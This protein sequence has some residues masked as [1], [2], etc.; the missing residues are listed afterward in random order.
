MGIKSA[1]P[2]VGN[3]TNKQRSI[4]LLIVSLAF[5]MDLLD[6]TIINIALPSI[7][8]SLGASFATIQWMVAGYI[9]TFALLLITGGRMGDVFGYKKMFLTGVGG[10]TIAS[11]LCGIAG[12]PEVLV[13]ARLLQGAMA[14]LMVPQVMSMV[15]VMY[16]PGERSKVMGLFGM[17]GGMA[18]TLGP[19]VGGILINANIF[20]LDWRPIFLI[21]LPVGIF[22]FIAGMKF[23]PEGKSPHPLRLDMVGTGILVVALSMLIFPLIQ[24]REL[25]W[26]DWTFWMLAASVPAFA[27]FAWHQRYKDRKD[28]SA[29]VEPSLFKKRTFSNGLMLNLIVQ[30]GMLGFFLT[31]TIALQAGLGFSVLNAALVG[32][33]SAMGI[34][35]SIAVVTQKI[36]PLLGRYT[37]TLGTVV[38]A[39][40][41]MITAW[42]ISHY[43]NSVAGWQFAPGL[44]IT[45][46]GLGAIMGTMFSV[47]L[48]DVDPKHAGSASGI[49]SAVQQI[50][51]ALGVAIIG[52]LFFGQLTSGAVSAF[53]KATPQLRQ[54]LTT[55]QV[56][57]ETQDQIIAGASTCFEDLNHQKDHAAM[58]ESC[59]QLQSAV[60]DTETGQAVQTAVLAASQD[61]NATNFGNAYK[62]GTVFVLGT[63]AIAFALS[64]TLPR[65]FKHTT[66]EVI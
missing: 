61:A 54:E 11:L 24:G 33:P 64:F 60:P 38:A 7:Q 12:S 23:L 62:W 66:A 17:L 47:T 56:P 26:P 21:N 59:Q 8:S 31:F 15:Q 46:L 49:M 28:N 43:G 58:P 30:A 52:V 40:G 4:A 1:G 6:A 63:L 44:F 20:N 48:Q 55:L 57:A 35:L 65:H 41:F 32:I 13:G 45:G 16:K 14:A 53:D 22:A 36:G 2:H 5:V 27:F 42:V 34:G 18:A 25:G 50:G 3:I 10:F 29:L 37:V 51:G 39:I 9:M 19:I